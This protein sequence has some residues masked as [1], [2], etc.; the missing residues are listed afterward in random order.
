M[1]QLALEV[2]AR[3]LDPA[4]ISLLAEEFDRADNSNNGEVRAN[5]C[6]RYFLAGTFLTSCSAAVYRRL[7][8]TS[9]P[10]RC[11]SAQH[12]AAQ[13]HTQ[14]VGLLLLLLLVMV[15]VV[16]VVI[17]VA[18]V[19]VAKTGAAARSQTCARRVFFVLPSSATTRRQSRCPCRSS[20]A[21]WRPT[22]RPEAWLRRKWRPSS[23][24]WTSITPVIWLSCSRSELLSDIVAF[25]DIF[26][27]DTPTN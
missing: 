13:Q 21:G 8:T 17:V 7:G 2:V 27:C 3:T 23:S 24:R 22:A 12:S 5:P 9:P 14:H 1:K 16:V 20:S 6:Q 10:F 4:Q 25:R 15:V 11:I 19:V 18:I 26:L